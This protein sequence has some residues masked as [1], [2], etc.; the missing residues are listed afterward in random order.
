MLRMIRNIGIA[1]AAAL[2]VPALADDL[3]S[4]EVG[5]DYRLVPNVTYLQAS[6]VEL[7]VDVIAPRDTASTRP[8]LLYIH[9]GGWVG[10]SKDFMFL[11]FLPY[12]EKGFAVVNVGYRLARTALAPAAVEDGRCALRWLIGNADQYGFD[13]DRIVVSGHSAGGHLSL[14]TGLLTADRGLDDRCPRTM[15]GAGTEPTEMPVAAIVNWFGI[16]D[17]GDLL[18]GPNAKS[19]AVAWMGGQPDADAIADRVSPINMVASDSAPVLTLHGDA[20]PI[21]PYAHATR[22]H[23][24]LDRAGV[25]NALHTIADG[26]HGGFSLDENRAAFTAIWAFLGEQGVLYE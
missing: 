5:Q 18:E 6:G 12:L 26:G 20:D 9:G 3:S 10:G 19:Y 25:E 21:V 17:V 7:K 2:M 16:T 22:L 14:T 24:F 13:T 1:I 4:L 11:H 8:T 15:A 23:A